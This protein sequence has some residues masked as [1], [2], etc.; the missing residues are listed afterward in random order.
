[1]TRRFRRWNRLTLGFVLAVSLSGVA[2]A[3]APALPEAAKTANDAS[4]FR[5]QIA[6]FTAHFAKQ[7]MEGDAKA[8]AG[9]RDA[10]SNA[11]SGQ[12]TFSFN[13]LYSDAL[14][15]ALLPAAGHQNI[16]V[17]LNVAIATARVAERTNSTRLAPLV[18][19]LLDDASPGVVIWSLR[20]SRPIA[21]AIL[22]DQLLVRNA[23]LVPLIVAAAKRNEKI[24][25]ITGEALAA[26]TGPLR[27]QKGTFNASQQQRLVP[28][29]ADAVHEILSF[30]VQQY[31][32]G[33]PSE[34][35]QDRAGT[36]FLVDTTY[37]PL[38]SDQQKAKT[39]ELTMW[40]AVLA[41]RRQVDLGAAARRELLDVISLQGKSLVLIADWT[42]NTGLR[43]AADPVS[44]IGAFSAAQQV[45]DWVKPLPEA[46]AATQQFRAVKA[47]PELQAASADVV[48]PA[49]G[50]AE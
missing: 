26:L 36:V 35:S 40:T 50:G 31:V 49:A 1:M 44:R 43:Q 4:S 38:L 15:N 39:V 8:V 9:A 7:M 12:T 28:I 32:T 41:G 33:I 21:T 17:R 19:K 23:N 46:V 2:L 16:V 34:P 5:P 47:P 14:S 48:A 30:R 20:A 37:W 42:K 18:R 45:V 11:V 27:E 13:E 3:Q 24:G 25:A 6:E 10:F 29:I 22:N